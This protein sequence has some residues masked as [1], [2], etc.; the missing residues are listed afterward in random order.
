MTTEELLKAIGDIDDDLVAEAETWS[1]GSP[2]IFRKRRKKRIWK[3]FLIGLAAAM[4]VIVVLPNISM[5]V[6]YA[7]EK[8]P[9]LSTIVKVVVWR[10]YHVEEG[11]YEANV[12]TPQLTLEAGE[13]S[14]ADTD[15]QLQQSVETINTSVEELTNQIIA[16]FEKG[17]EADEELEGADSISV[18]HEIL[19][20][21]ERYFSMKVWVVEAMGSGY[22][23]DYYYTIDRRTGKILKLADLFEDDSYVETISEEIKRQMRR[24][25]AEDENAIYW[26]DDPEVSFWNFEQIDRD[27]SFYISSAGELIICFNEGDVAPMYMG[28]VT[29]DMPMEVWKEPRD[30][31]SRSDSLK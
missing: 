2:E 18:G 8:L 15:E 9:V 1:E 17:L 23:L 30:D 12:S 22:E 4:A 31:A 26:L 16:E 20:D 5:S 24:E 14:D 19:T 29:F 28:C 7:W 3:G 27:Q 6:A 11:R 21:D 10:D 25:M 13:E